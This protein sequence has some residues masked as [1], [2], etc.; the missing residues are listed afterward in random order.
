MLKYR[1][2]E[3]QGV[4]GL[5]HP[6]NELLEDSYYKEKKQIPPIVGLVFGTTVCLVINDPEVN[7]ELFLTKNK[8]FDKHPKTG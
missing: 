8:Y 3:E 2:N 6:I 7:Q 1:P 4:K 5:G